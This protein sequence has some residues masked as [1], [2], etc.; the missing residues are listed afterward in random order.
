MVLGFLI[1]GTISFFNYEK[2]NDIDVVV[3][4]SFSIEVSPLR[5][6]LEGWVCLSSFL[7]SLR[8]MLEKSWS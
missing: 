2:L 1:S 7:L 6:I 3:S 4:L 8:L 5:V